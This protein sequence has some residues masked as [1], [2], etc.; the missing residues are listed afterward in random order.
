MKKTKDKLSQL[1]H[2][3]VVK[4]LH[5]STF[6]PSLTKETLDKHPLVVGDITIQNHAPLNWFYCVCSY[7]ARKQ[8][9]IDTFTVALSMCG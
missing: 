7:T 2:Q 9:V 8:L 6:D 1:P 4:Y 5:K 3:S